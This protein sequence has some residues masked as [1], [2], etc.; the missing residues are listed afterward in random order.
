MG[1]VGAR[2]VG[3]FAAVTFIA[4]WEKYC[5]AIQYDPDS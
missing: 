2:S 3:F 5:R 4:Q 1:K